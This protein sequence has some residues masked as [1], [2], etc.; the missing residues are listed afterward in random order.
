MLRP[1]FL[2]HVRQLS[3]RVMS[4]VLNPDQHLA[5]VRFDSAERPEKPFQLND[6]VCFGCAQQ[7]TSLRISRHLGKI[8]VERS[9]NNNFS[10]RD[11]LP[12][13]SRSLSEAETTY[14]LTSNFFCQSERQETH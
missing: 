14:S 13:W 11:V 7:T 4:D 6:V 12:K 3:N 5:T 8:V 10:Y 9:R 1:A 2:I